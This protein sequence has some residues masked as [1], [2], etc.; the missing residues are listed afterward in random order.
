MVLCYDYTCRLYYCL[1]TELRVLYTF[2]E[3]NDSV[4]LTFMRY[5]IEWSPNHTDYLLF[6]A[7]RFTLWWIIP[8]PMMYQNQSA[9]YFWLKRHHPLAITVT[10][11]LKRSMF[12]ILMIKMKTADRKTENKMELQLKCWVSFPLHTMIILLDLNVSFLL[13][14]SF[15][16]S[17][18]F[19]GQMAPKAIF[20][21][22]LALAS[23]PRSLFYNIN[24][25]K[26]KAVECCNHNTYRVRQ[27]QSLI[28][29]SWNWRNPQ[30]PAQVSFLWSL[31][32]KYI[33]KTEWPV[34]VFK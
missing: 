23:L 25:N 3:T 12:D 11:W 5:R 18:I 30:V 32:T 8:A 10:E 21:K 31:C 24:N 27:R 22:T 15:L 28:D 19:W 33:N 34:N 29:K 26:Q 17:F 6:E 9:C 16:L 4:L 13:F 7:N 14:P 20:N 2:S 1:Y